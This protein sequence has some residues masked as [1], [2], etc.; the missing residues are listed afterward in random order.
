MLEDTN[1]NK[2]NNF[3]QAMRGILIICVVLI[4]SLS[5]NRD[6][7]LNNE[8]NIIIRTIINF[9]VGTF[10]FLSGFFIKTDEIKTNL[11]NFYI[12]RFKRIVIPYIIWSFLY[13]CFNNIEYIKEFNVI[14]IIYSTIC[15]TSGGQLYY[16]I[17]LVQLIILTPI[18]TYIYNK[19][20]KILNLCIL[21]ITPLYTFINGIFNYYLEKNI[22]LYATLFFAWISFYYLGILFRNTNLNKFKKRWIIVLTLVILILNIGI[23][24][25]EYINLNLSYSYCTSQIKLSNTIYIMVVIF[26]IFTIYNK[27]NNNL[28]SNFLTKIG[29]NSFGIYFIH[30]F[31]ISIFNKVLINIDCINIVKS[32]IITILSI[33]GS[34]AF[35]KIF[36]ILT[37]NKLKKYLGF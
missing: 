33:I 35:I 4:H 30:L 11:L 6:I 18:F 32:V 7:L 10:I 2:R 37:K 27:H 14:K 19:N 5:E 16:I 28:K 3:F 17:A 34:I 21:S 36:N 1:K 9:A 31:F 20:N 12:K 29:D 25:F 22:P 24:L 13:T 26:T 23:N 15:G 8:L